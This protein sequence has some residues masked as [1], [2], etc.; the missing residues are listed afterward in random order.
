MTLRQKISFLV[1]LLATSM[2]ITNARGA[3]PLVAKDQ[4]FVWIPIQD[5]VHRE[6]AS[7][8]AH[9]LLFVNFLREGSEPGFLFEDFGAWRG[10]SLTM[11][12]SCAGT[13]SKLGEL[14]VL[15]RLEKLVNWRSTFSTN[16]PGVA[17]AK[18]PGIVYSYPIE[19]ETV[20]AS[21]FRLAAGKYT[22]G[23]CSVSLRFS[24]LD[25]GPYLPPGWSET[26]MNAAARLGL[27][28]LLIAANSV[29]KSRKIFVWYFDRCEQRLGMSRKIA[30][31]L[32]HAIDPRYQIELRVESRALKDIGLE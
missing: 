6:K 19:T 32:H 10:L 26:S 21:F 15:P 18:T 23:E 12:N 30:D 29:A 7:H 5:S 3:S 25:S 17:K 31:F 28:V 4:C 9:Q 13:L 24:G 20:R 8:E 2:G 16:D 27:P 11:H 14:S 1:I 22:E